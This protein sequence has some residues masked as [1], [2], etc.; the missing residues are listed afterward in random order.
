VKLQKEFGTFKAVTTSFL[1]KFKKENYESISGYGMDGLD[2]I[3]AASRPTLE[4][5]SLLSN[6]Y[7]RRFLRG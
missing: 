3:P 1:G 7:R 2:L 5:S 6:R 4:P